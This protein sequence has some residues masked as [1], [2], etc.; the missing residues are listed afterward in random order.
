[1]TPVQS[2][3]IP[4]FMKNKDVVVEAVTGSGKTLAF[5]I[6]IIEKLLR[7]E[8]PLKGNQVGAMVITPTRELAQQIHSVFELFVR[9]H[10]R[11]DQLTLGL[12]IGGTTTL[13]Q[14]RETFTK[15]MPRILIG[16]PGRLEELLKSGQLI[17]TKE[18]EVLVMD[19]ADRLLDMGFKQQLSGIIAQLPK[20][21]RTGL[22]SA[23]MTEAISELIRAGL[24]NPVRIVVKVHDLVQNQQRTPSTL[25]IDYIVCEP[26]QKLLQLVRILEHQ[27]ATGGATKFIVY[28]STC[29]CVDYFYKLLHKKLK[30]MS[31][32]V[33]SLHGQ[34]DTK[35]RAAT[36]N[37]FIQL[38]PAVPAVLLCTDVASRGLDIPDV[39]Y[40]IQVDPPQDP[41]AFTHRAGRAA[42]AGRQGRA[43][44]LLCRGRE[45][46][47]VDFLKLRKVP[48]ER[49]PYRL[50]DGQEKDNTKMVQEDGEEK[51][52]TEPVDDP[53][54]TSFVE[55]LRQV[56]KV[57]RDMHDRGMKAF[58]SWVRSYS[59]HEAS[60][61]F[62]IKDLDLGQVATSFALLKLPKMPELKDTKQI[63]F[64]P[65]DIDWN[66][67]KYQDKN[68]ENKRQ[69]EAA[70]PAPINKKPKKQV[71]EAWS[72][73]KEA[74]MKKQER[75]TK[76]ERKKEYLKRKA[77][78]V[79]KDDEQDNDW[80]DLAA[81]ERM[82]KKVRKGKVNQKEFDNMFM[83]EKDEE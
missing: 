31:F 79:E 28:F 27:L 40:V 51:I 7:R 39:D 54:L 60:F 42:R 68:R 58:A 32:T 38:A 66:N 30:N 52:V 22:F 64:T 25:R 55:S 20:Q 35:R 21:R 41:K 70:A 5:V 49:A 8:D 24:R 63:T 83:D 1:M 62:R 14:D 76:K 18:F 12:F 44:A 65:A 78:Q 45:E 47:Y 74:K 53:E 6:P 50:P 4:L 23:T 81:E 71:T 15:T 77:D 13:A 67:Y 43:T 29:A 73:K 16:T 48:M 82:A 33:H 9:D 61:I 80:D 46:L 72:A 2:G 37:S 17:N 59:K 36:Y 69:R 19:E 26:N 56:I 75:R 34:M 11:K 3:A 10:P 57:D